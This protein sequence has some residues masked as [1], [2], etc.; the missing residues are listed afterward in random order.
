MGPPASLGADE[1]QSRPIIQ[2]AAELGINF[3]DTA[4]IYSMA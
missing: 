1:D 3:F 2:R 4:D